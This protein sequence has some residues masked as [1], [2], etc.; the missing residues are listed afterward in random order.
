MVCVSNAFLLSSIH[1]KSP[2]LCVKFGAKSSAFAVQ[3][4]KPKC[5]GHTILTATFSIDNSE[6]NAPKNGKLT[7]ILSMNYPFSI[8]NLKV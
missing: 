1:G 3:R 4:I 7:K 5:M 2:E 6:R 8:P